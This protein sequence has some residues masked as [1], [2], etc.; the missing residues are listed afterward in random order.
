MKKINI[1]DIDF[2]LDYE[3]YIWYSNDRKPKVNPK[4]TKEDFKILPFIIEG[5]LYC[6]DKNISISIK[7]YDGK[8]H[9]YQVELNNFSKDQFT[10]Q[11][12]LSHGLNGVSK[13][14]MLHY[15]KE[16]EPDELLAG[17]KTLLPSW[18]AFAGFI[19]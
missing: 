17:M 5:N 1:D 18:Q 2:N 16:S 3:G 14:K 12:Y 4:I 11:Q 10:E 6:K 7:N 8:Y 15:W 19:K 13:L 9:V